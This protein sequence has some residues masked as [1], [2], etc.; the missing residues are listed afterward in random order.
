MFLVQAPSDFWIVTK[1]MCKNCLR[2]A[3]TGQC[4]SFL[5]QP[6][7]SL[8]FYCFQI[9]QLLNSLKVQASLQLNLDLFVAHLGL[10]ING[11]F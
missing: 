4:S 10:L 3:Q 7:V 1:A 6:A 2:R 11:K 8:R 9:I 5:F